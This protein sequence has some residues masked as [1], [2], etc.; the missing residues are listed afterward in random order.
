MGALI[1][2]ALSIP[3]ILR[4]PSLHPAVVTVAVAVAFWLWQVPGRRNAALSWGAALVAVLCLGLVVRWAQQSY[5][6]A[7]KPWALGVI[8]LAVATYAAREGVRPLLRAGAICFFFLVGIYA[9]ILVFGLGNISQIR[10]AVWKGVD[11]KDLNLVWLLLPLAVHWMDTERPS[12]GW[13][14]AWAAICLLPC[15][16][17]WLCLSPEVAERETFA[18]YTLTKSISVLGVMERFEVV[19]SAAMTAGIFC[20]MGVFGH[21]CGKVLE[22][23][24]PGKNAYLAVFALGVMAS[25]LAEDWLMVLIAILAPIF[26]LLGPLAAYFVKTQKKTEKSA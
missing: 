13:R 10:P 22:R 21:I 1:F 15:L 4:F 8:L 7:Q 26:W 5:P 18:F 14:W 24:I 23:V 9:V 12:R 6:S 25:C 3:A 17:C 2:C 11:V 20:L 19:L 16:V